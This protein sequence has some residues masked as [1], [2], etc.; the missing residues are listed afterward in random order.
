MIGRREFISLL[1]GA[2]AT[3][4]LA[5]RAQQPEQMRRIGV[6][7]SQAESDPVAQSYIATFARRRR[8]NQPDDVRRCH[9]V[10]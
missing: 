2:A 10:R 6:L 3:W 1:G 4:P 5:A 7:L 9:T 8:L